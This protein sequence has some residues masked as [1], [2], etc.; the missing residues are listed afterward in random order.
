M[1]AYVFLADNG[2]QMCVSEVDAT[3][4]FQALAGGSISEEQ[5]ADWFYKNCE[6]GRGMPCTMT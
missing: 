4:T 5:I 2:S 3:L 1:A 6:N